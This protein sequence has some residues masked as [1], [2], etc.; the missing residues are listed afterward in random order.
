V[1]LS[2]PFR[3]RRADVLEAKER[4]AHDKSLGILA[5][6]NSRSATDSLFL[7]HLLRGDALAGEGPRR[8]CV[9]LLSFCHF[10]L[11]HYK[12]KVTCYQTSPS[13]PIPP[14]Q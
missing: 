1:L 11:K 13:K 8:R 3:K 7:E 2:S 6:G 10:D 12:F 9:T 4:E 14:S 5:S